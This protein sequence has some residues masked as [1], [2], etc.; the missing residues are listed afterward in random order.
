MRKQAYTTDID[1]PLVWGSLRLTPIICKYVYM[2]IMYNMYMFCAIWEVAQSADCI[3]Q[4]KDPQIAC[5]SAD[6]MCNLQIAQMQSAQF[7]DG[8]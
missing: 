8:V 6:C 2:Y 4:S 1:D 7:M 3:V 5:Q